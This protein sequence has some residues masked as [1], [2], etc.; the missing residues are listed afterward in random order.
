MKVAWRFAGW[1][2]MAVL[3]LCPPGAAADPVGG[4]TFSERVADR[5]TPLVLYGQGLYR[6]KGFLKGYAI[7][8]YLG[9]R[10]SPAAVLS[11]V[12]KRLELE[13]FWSIRGKDFA[14]A[15][16]K[17]LGENVSKETLIQLRARL[18][19]LKALY[20]DVKPG[21][22]YSLT[23]IPG[24]GT[25]LALNGTPLGTIEGADFASAYFS[26]WLGK[27]PMSRPLKTQLLTKYRR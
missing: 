7:A 15:G 19:L 24:S 21:D 4:V 13:Y 10:V 8:L 26:I 5:N 2:P 1:V 14:S 6:W 11:D 27:S 18:D 25:Q 22:R 9:E 23:Y 12:P 17:I 3:F 20:K 16:E